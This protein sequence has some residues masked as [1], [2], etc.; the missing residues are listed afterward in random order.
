MNDELETG[1][2]TESESVE[3]T[4][5]AA[6]KELKGGLDDAGKG[7]KQVDSILKDLENETGDEPLPHIP[8]LKDDDDDDSAVK[9]EGEDSED[10]KEE[11]PKEVVEE[12]KA[13]QSWTA[14]GKEWFNAQP[15]E[16]RKELAK[17]T[18]ELETHTYKVWEEANKIKKNYKDLDEV[19]VPFEK[20]WNLKG[21]TRAQMIL[22]LAQSQRM[23]SE[24]PE[25]GLD[26]IA[27]SYGTSLEDIVK[28]R[29]EQ[30]EGGQSQSS[31]AYD[32]QADAVLQQLQNQVQSLQNE[33]N[34]QNQ[35][36]DSVRVQ[37]VVAELHS[38]R[39]EV[40]A[41]GRFLRP[42][43]HD[44][45]FV[46]RLGPIYGGLMQQPGMTPQEAIRKAYTAMTGKIPSAQPQNFTASERAKKAALSVRGG[47]RPTGSRLSHVDSKESAEDTVFRI[48]RELGAI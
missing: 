45:S 47:S 10:S 33:L 29:L 35:A 14:K 21:F 34:R 25:A 37:S 42:E 15:I 24:S 44:A 38:V 5:M 19:L 43:M 6:Y 30:E 41:S 4:V 36:Q 1:S 13:P 8:D 40:D 39:D 28:R 11:K 26:Y 9:V 22:S 23:L 48:A 31:E 16:A 32:P 3:D 18:K 46:R 2:V 27:K 17:R 12:V 7:N 20:D